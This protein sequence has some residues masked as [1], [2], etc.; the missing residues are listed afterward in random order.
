MAT[1]VLM[2]IPPDA[3][4]YLLERLNE[5]GAA[6]WMEKLIVGGGFLLFSIQMILAWRSLRWRGTSFNESGD[7]WLINLAQSAEWFPMLGLI[8]TVSGILEAFKASEGGKAIQP[9]AIAPALTATGAGL[10]M[11]LINIL[12]SWIVLMGRDLILIL[13]GTPSPPPGESS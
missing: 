9:A 7:R 4:H 12:P 13:N 10:F 3:R 2:C 6:V 1:L 5:W 8:G 11:A